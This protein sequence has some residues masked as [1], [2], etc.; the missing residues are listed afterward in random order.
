MAAPRVF[1]E[2]LGCKL[3]QAERDELFQQFAKAGCRMVTSI[4]DADIYI[5]NTC[6]VTHIADRKSRHLLRMA[7]RNNPDALLVATGCYAQRESQELAKIDGVRFTFGNKDKASILRVLADHGFI[8]QPVHDH[9]VESHDSFRTRAMIKIQDGCSNFCTYCI[10]PL[11]GGGEKSR[12][13]QEV[14]DSVNERVAAGYREI[15]LTGVRI[16]SYYSNG[17]DLCGLLERILGETSV[18]RLRLS[19][20]QPGEISTRLIALWQNER[21]CPHFHLCLQSGSDQI[22][23]MMGRR[24]ST[25]DFE[26]TVSSIRQKLPDVAITTDVMVGF[27]GESDEHFEESY[28]FCRRTGFSRMHVFSYSPRNDTE[29]SRYLGQVGDGVK[30]ERADRMLKLAKDESLAFMRRFLGRTVQVLFER[31]SRRIWTGLTPN[32]IRV[33]VDSKSDIANCLR[34][35]K[36]VSPYRDGVWGEVIK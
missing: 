2:S 8:D 30:K 28:R 21:L 22:L 25:A 9:P 29:A 34:T 10:V 13:V 18:E 36:L 1:L 35:V 32:Y 27:P 7:H 14:V 12:T 4:D 16:G 26:Q 24:Y 6:T 33:Y 15:V 3:N 31:I 23:R 5:L 19:S 17:V 20:L 11:V